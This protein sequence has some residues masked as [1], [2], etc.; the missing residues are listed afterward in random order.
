ME[1][2]QT[3]NDPDLS[4]WPVGTRDAITRDDST[5]PFVDVTALRSPDAIARMIVAGAQDRA[6]SRPVFLYIRRDWLNADATPLTGRQ[7]WIGNTDWDAQAE[8]MSW[9]IGRR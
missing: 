6:C 1:L 2:M 7:G 9:R 5:L 8:E 4:L 3:L